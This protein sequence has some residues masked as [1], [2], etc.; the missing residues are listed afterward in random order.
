M[1]AK[2]VILDPLVSMKR[3]IE[4]IG[5]PSLKRKNLIAN[6]NHAYAIRRKI[7]SM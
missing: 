7:I 5:I 1:V 6:V 4:I 3:H 2:E